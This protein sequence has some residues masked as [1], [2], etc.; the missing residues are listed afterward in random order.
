MTEQETYEH[1]R[2]TAAEPMPPTLPDEEYYRRR[3]AP[4]QTSGTARLGALLVLI[5]L[6]WLIVELIGYGPFGAGQSI[7]RIPAPLPN[8][9]LELHLGS[10]DVEVVPGNSQEVTIEAT[11]YGLWRGNPAVVSQSSEGVR[12]TNETTPRFGLCFGRCGLSYRVT[13]PRGVNMAAQMS[14]GDV[15]IS[16]ADGAISITIA[17]GDVEAHD[18]ANG[19]TVNSSS[20]DVTLERVGGKLDVRTSSGDVQLEEGQVADAAVQT[21]SGNIELDGVA[22]ALAL[23]SSS[24]DITVRDARNGRLAI[25]TNSGDVDYTGG[26]ASDGEHSVAASSGDVTLRLPAASSFALEVSTSSGDLRNDFELRG[27]QRD[28]RT[29]TGAAGA[30]GSELKITT[31]SG[32]IAIERQ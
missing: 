14:S 1:S 6:V 31:S 17:S 7:T 24:G 20:G 25:Q 30:G 11:Q 22:G 10:G 12:V 21:N 27:E 8:N 19:I 4:R 15:E 3:Q 5:G 2:D 9:R 13:M 32:D 28:G 29:L 26:L 16:E 23:R 18:I